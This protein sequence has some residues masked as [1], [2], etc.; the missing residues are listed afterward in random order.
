MRAADRIE[1]FYERKREPV[2]EHGDLTRCG[3]YWL[4]ESKKTGQK[5]FSGN[6]DLSKIDVE[7]TDTVELMVFRNTKKESDKHPDYIISAKAPPREEGKSKPS[8][9]VDDDVP[10]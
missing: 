8:A 6:I 10:F 4:R 5:Y 9:K 2:S 3:A 7:A 1:D